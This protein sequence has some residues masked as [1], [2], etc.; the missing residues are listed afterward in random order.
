MV[1]K[2]LKRYLD[3]YFNEWI[4]KRGSYP[5]VSYDEDK[6][7]NLYFGE[8]DEDDDI[9]WKYTLN[10]KNINFGSL[11]DE[12]G[13]QINHEVKEFYS[14]Y[15]FLQLE[16]FYNDELIWIDPITDH[17]DIISEIKYC[18]D[19][20]GDYNVK[21]G[22]LGNSNLPIYVEAQTGKVVVIDREKNK[23][24]CLTQSISEFIGQLTPSKQK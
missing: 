2:E 13:I 9:Q 19:V 12:Y 3:D 1:K 11:E 14:S 16:G 6:I 18:F 10:D 24:Y 20:E 23:Q 22:L 4:T 8:L 15:L 21:I 17:T 7:S 5:M